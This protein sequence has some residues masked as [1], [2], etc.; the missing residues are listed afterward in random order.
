MPD[1]TLFTATLMPDSDWWQALWPDPIGVLRQVGIKPGMRVVDLCC[2][3]GHFARP[4]CELV[5]PGE[6]LAMDLDPGLLQQA[7]QACADQ[8]NFHAV[9]GDARSLP[10]R[11]DGLVDFVFIAN[12]FHGVP[13]KT[14]L[15]KAVHDTLQPGGLF[16]IVNWYRQPR[17]ET[18]V[19]GQ[20][21]RLSETPGT[22]RE[23]APEFGQH[24]EEVLVDLLGY[25]W[26]TV[27]DFRKRE[28]I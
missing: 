17:E 22:V 16:A 14:D 26:D 12:T 11:I 6:A 5:N 2:G 21:Y 3:D 19:L 15:S 23:P 27:T 9:L 20:P 4:L 13:D 25:D 18:Q 24:T 10:S 28:V 1:E 8:S 7:A